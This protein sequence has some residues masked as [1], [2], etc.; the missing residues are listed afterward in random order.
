MKLAYLL[1]FVTFLTSCNSRNNSKNYKDF[2]YDFRVKGT[3]YIVLEEELEFWIDDGRKISITP[4][5]HLF[6]DSINIQHSIK[7][8]ILTLG[9]I[10][11]VTINYP[12]E[13][14]LAKYHTQYLFLIG[15]KQKNT[16]INSFLSP[17]CSDTFKLTDIKEVWSSHNGRRILITFVE[18]GNKPMRGYK[19]PSK[20]FTLN[21]Y[22]LDKTTQITL[23]GKVGDFTKEFLHLPEKNKFSGVYKLKTEKRNIELLV[24]DGMNSN[25]LT[26]WLKLFDNNKSVY[27]YGF[28]QPIKLNN[29]LKF[30]EDIDNIDH[31]WDIKLQFRENEVE[32]LY[33]DCITEE[34]K[35]IFC[36]INERLE[37]K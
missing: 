36:N 3:Q 9:R 24:K 22:R 4:Y 37:K 25:L 20:S 19:K 5:L 11:D 12:F 7:D 15:D 35:E 21:N 10:N 27:R 8:T 31:H 28:H 34:F 30:S 6:E 16:I 23:E 1:L 13:I 14:F 33:N 17:P 32:M 26:F 29:I 18:I 2:T